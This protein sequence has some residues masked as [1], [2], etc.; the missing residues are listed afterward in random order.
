MRGHGGW[1]WNIS[2]NSVPPGAAPINAVE[3]KSAVL[4]DFV[5]L[6]CSFRPMSSRIFS[7]VSYV[8]FRM[9]FVM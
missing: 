2:E 3:T 6:L 5:C 9:G 8:E 7:C 1:I 4:L